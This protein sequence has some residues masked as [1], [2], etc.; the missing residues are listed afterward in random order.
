ET[1]EAMSRQ[2]R[3]IGYSMGILA[4]LFTGLAAYLMGRSVQG[5]MRDILASVRAIKD[6]AYDKLKVHERRSD[7]IGEVGRALMVLRDRSIER[8]TLAKERHD[9]VEARE[10]RHAA[11]AE[12]I[13]EFQK[14]IAAN[15]SVLAHVV[16]NLSQTSQALSHVSDD[17]TEKTGATATAVI[18]ASDNV[19]RV[20]GATDQLSVSVSEVHG[21]TEESRNVAE[22]I[23]HTVRATQPTM[24][25]LQ[26]STAKIGQAIG[27]IQSIAAQT[28]LLSLNATIEAARAGEAGRGFSVVAQEVK[29]LAGQTE[30][31]AAEV[32]GLIAN[33]RSVAQ[34]ASAAFEGIAASIGTLA[35]NTVGI[36]AAVS[37]QKHGIDE[38]T[39]SL[40][41]AS[42]QSQ[43]GSGAMNEVM[44]LAGQSAEVAISVSEVADLIKTC[45]ADLDRD[46]RHFLTQVRAA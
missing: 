9:E 33:V 19:M 24:A 17:L 2:S 1:A 38:I 42:E 35:T 16:G 37:E 12:H 13:Q 46:V 30:N 27:L 29:L 21:H 32:R 4:A 41:A 20:A 45:A 36:A 43:A 40:H 44:A 28:N 11:R 34:D 6:G 5:A 14:A 31:A 23:S 18:G 3:I 10:K 26:E 22:H 7:E 25:R 39:R 8:D 15:L